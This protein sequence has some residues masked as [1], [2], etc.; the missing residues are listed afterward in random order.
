MVKSFFCCC[1]F[2]G[3]GHI[4]G[5]MRAVGSDT[6]PQYEVQP[7]VTDVYGCLNTRGLYILWCLNTQVQDFEETVIDPFGESWFFFTVELE[8]IVS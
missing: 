7:C 1:Y 6:L 4:F 5:I 8:R 2:L 3:C